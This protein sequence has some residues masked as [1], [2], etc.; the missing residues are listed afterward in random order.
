MG[1][2][3]SKI[4][5]KD[6]RSNS[7]RGKSSKDPAVVVTTL[8]RRDDAFS[9][10]HP[11]TDWYYLGKDYAAYAAIRSAHPDREKINDISEIFHKRADQHWRDFLA[12]SS[13][14]NRA[15][16][17]IFYWSSVIASRNVHTIPLFRFFLYLLIA[18]EISTGPNPRRPIGF[19]VEDIVLGDQLAEILAKEG[20]SVDFWGQSELISAR[21]RL[22]VK[23]VARGCFFWFRAF[24]RHWYCIFAAPRP[25]FTD[26]KN[27]YVLRP[28]ASVVNFNSCGNFSDRNFG[29]LVYFL[30][31]QSKFVIHYPLFIGRN[32]IQDLRA[33]VNSTQNFLIQEQFLGIRD[34]LA[35][36]VQGVKLAFLKMPQTSF[37]GLD[38][39]RIVLW[40]HLR[41]VLSPEEMGYNLSI[42]LLKQLGKIGIDLEKVIYP[43]ENNSQEKVLIR[44]LRAYFPKTQIVGYQHTVWF[45][46]QYGMRLLPEELG[47]HPLPDVIVSSA[48]VY[49]DILEE[50][51]FPP[52]IVRPGPNLRFKVGSQVSSIV[53]N[54]RMLLVLSY[55]D[56]EATGLVIRSCEAA[57]SLSLKLSEI[58]I[59]PHPLNDVSK[60]AD[61]VSRFGDNIR[62][63]MVSGA[64]QDLVKECQVV[65]CGPSSVVNLEVSSLGVPLIR[66]SSM[67]HFNIEPVWEH[68]DYW[69]LVSSHRELVSRL[70]HFLKIDSQEEQ[71]ILEIARS[72]RDKY[73]GSCDSESF[74]VFT[75]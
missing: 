59:K 21:F 29:N 69:S 51:G 45:Q 68:G 35:T 20:V 27:I 52:S 62:V 14:L 50:T 37:C 75:G 10:A 63:S 58:W 25:S 3:A 38:V 70:E 47:T 30:R 40:C 73:F 41:T 74:H 46:R 23:I 60:L 16:D 44:G 64:L 1:Q 13:V 18:K 34:Y 53:K 39:R 7:K 2:I 33:Q 19:I 9:Q 22:L 61:L 55:D 72:I 4:P 12:F 57:Q 5:G 67:G 65:I 48:P 17:G 56:D 24:I 28:W 36:F 31:K 26:A 54:S 43:M 15:N 49:A 32:F 66:L 42:R 11:K 71:Y 6:R 8:G